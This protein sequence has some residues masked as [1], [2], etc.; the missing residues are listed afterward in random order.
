[1]LNAAQLFLA[2]N[3]L[4]DHAIHCND[5]RECTFSRINEEAVEIASRTVLTASESHM[6]IRLVTPQKRHKNTRFLPAFPGQQH[7][8]TVKGGAGVFGLKRCHV[9]K[10]GHGTGIPWWGFHTGTE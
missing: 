5:F 4:L 1:M 10:A 9:E 3:G 7:S 2:E 6:L 8:N